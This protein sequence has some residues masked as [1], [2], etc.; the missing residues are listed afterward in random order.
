MTPPFPM[1][2]WALYA[3]GGLVLALALAT[4][5]WLVRRDGFRD[6]RAAERAVWEEAERKLLKKVGEAEA[7]ADK[8]AAAREA[9]HAAAVA[10][11]RKKID[12]AVAKG[13]S[14]FDVL[15]GS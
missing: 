7:K 1:P 12:E 3:L 9:E 2:R 14:P 13:D 8:K 11:E 6:G 4:A 15:F 5:L 10:E